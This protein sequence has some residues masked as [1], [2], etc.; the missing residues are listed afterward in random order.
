MGQQTIIHLNGKQYNAI[1]GELIGESRIKAT[2]EKRA[3]HARHT[4]RTMDGV[5]RATA[6]PARTSTAATGKASPST[7]AAALKP[8]AKKFDIQ[9]PP[10][11]QV[12]HR[13]PE[14]SKT[15]M[16]HVVPKPAVERKPAIKTTATAG[17]MA[18]PVS[19]IASPLEKKLS[20]GHVDPI[21]L[22]HAKHTPKSHHIKRFTKHDV[23]PAQTALGAKPAQVATPAVVQAIPKPTGAVM[24]TKPAVQARTANADIFEAALARANSHTASLPKKTVGRRGRLSTR[25]ISVVAGIAAFLVIGGFVTYLNMPALELRVASI[26]AGFQAEMPR[27]QP[28]GY[29]ME[30]D[31]KSSEGRIAMH[32][33]S[34]DSGYTITQTASDWNSQTLLDAYT[35]KHG[36]PERTVQSQ[37]RIIYLYDETRATWVNGGVQYEITG[38]A[39]LTSEDLVSLATSM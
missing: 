36:A 31:I 38:N 28:L 9:R 8:A 30:G 19:D 14:R 17:I 18:K 32:F 3:A 22:S 29:A 13:Q 33:R 1:T 23:S 35:D 6:V 12:K 26:R 11:R 25:L 16:R 2:P 24:A 21:R 4:G 15:L 7:K 20:V 5:V 27:Y 39:S 10:T 37:G 34:G